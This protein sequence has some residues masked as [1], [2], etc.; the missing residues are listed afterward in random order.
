MSSTPHS[1]FQLSDRKKAIL[2][3]LLSKEGMAP[4]EDR[5]PRRRE[6]GPA[7]LS[8]SQQR[9]WFFD[10]FEPAS[11]TYN[12]LTAVS[13]GG[14]LKI[15][16]LQ[17]AFGEVVRRH[18]ALRTTF[19]VRD[20]QPVQIINEQHS[21]RL[22]QIDIAH[23]SHAEQQDRIRELLREQILQPFDL[24]KGPL[25][26]I[27]LIRLAANDYV[28]AM[29]MHHI[30][31]DGWSMNVLVREITAAYQAYSSGHTPDLPPLPLQYADFAVWQ[32]TW[33]QGDVL[34][35]QLEYW[36]QQLGNSPTVL[37]LPA[38]RPRPAVQTYNGA[39]FTFAFSPSLSHHSKRCAGERA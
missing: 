3:A 35:Q 10:Q 21:I 2:D 7:P 37:E 27:T 30:V 38:N 20:G 8:F 5:I 18:E 33:L 29:A 13:L 12:L 16:A 28:L 9:L 15:D 23:L 34:A 1:K 6:S 17:E 32:R 31:S 11:F 4:S 14:D 25:L 24:K 26:R 22:C 39:D 36:K 19:D